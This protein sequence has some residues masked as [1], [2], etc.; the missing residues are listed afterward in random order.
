MRDEDYFN[1]YLRIRCAAF[2]D[3]VL[4][5]KNEYGQQGYMIYNDRSF[6]YISEFI[7]NKEYLDDILKTI[8]V[9]FYKDIRIRNRLHSV[10]SW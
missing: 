5:F 10:Y 3:S 8:S 4:T 2:N 6:V 1:N 9:Y 7:Y